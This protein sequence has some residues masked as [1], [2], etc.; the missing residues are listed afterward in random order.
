VPL[1]LA[2]PFVLLIVIALIPLSLIQRYRV[3]TS[4]QRARAWLISLNLAGLAISTVMFLVGAGFS[5]IWVPDALR[6]SLA[7][8]A[9]G[10]LLGLVGLLVTMW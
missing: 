10:A 8:L 1:L 5:S 6:Y 2:I 7:G 9:A 4:R 3:S